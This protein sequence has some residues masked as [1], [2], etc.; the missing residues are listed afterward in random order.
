M[1]IKLSI[2]IATMPSRYAK[3][4]ALYNCLSDQYM[5][6]DVE[7]IYDE[8][9]DY[10]I[11]VKRNKLLAKASGEYVVF[12]DDDDFVVQDYIVQILKAIETKP[13]CVGIMGTISFNGNGTRQWFIS[14]EY[15]HWYEKNGIFFR[16]PNH[17]SPVRRELALQ[18][19]FPEI[20][21]AEDADY[22]KRLLPLLKTETLITKNIYHYDYWKK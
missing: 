4:L 20:A 21:F 5:G 9:M 6:A 8:S 15:G 2:L 18:V 17:I 13:D 11:G 7:L 10:N 1:E 12:V 14:K 19:G 3:F 22:S 16:T